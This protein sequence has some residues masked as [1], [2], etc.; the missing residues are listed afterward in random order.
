MR[1]ARIDSGEPGVSESTTEILSEVYGF[2]RQGLVF[3]AWNRTGILG[4]FNRARQSRRFFNMFG[5][6]MRLILGLRR[7]R[8]LVVLDKH[9]LPCHLLLRSFRT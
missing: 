9:W 7:E 5:G 6:L 2:G 3:S 4:F 8:L 1:L